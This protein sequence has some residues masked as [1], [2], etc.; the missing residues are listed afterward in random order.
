MFRLKSTFGDIDMIISAVMFD[1]ISL[2]FFTRQC[3]T[4]L[5]CHP[6]QKFA[7]KALSETV[8]LFVC[9]DLPMGFRI[10]EYHCVL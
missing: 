5:F 7:S 2:V 3:S 8:L 9:L 10:S 6:R 4:A 1:A